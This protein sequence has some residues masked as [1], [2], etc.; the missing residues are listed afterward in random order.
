MAGSACSSLA[1]AFALRSGLAVPLDDP[2][3]AKFRGQ[4]QG[5]PDQFIEHRFR[6]IDQAGS[7]GSGNN[8]EKPH[9]C[10]ALRNGRSPPAPFID[11]QS[12]LRMEFISGGAE[13]FSPDDS[14]AEIQA[15]AIRLAFERTRPT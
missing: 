14:A 4:S 9:N 12:A 13:V 5:H 2:R 6:Q 3:C 1:V 7:F 8:T 11:E 15:K 10:K